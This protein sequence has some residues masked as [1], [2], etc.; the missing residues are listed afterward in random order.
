MMPEYRVMAWTTSEKECIKPS[1]L[2]SKGRTARAMS[3]EPSVMRKPAPIWAALPGQTKIK[4]EACAQ[5]RESH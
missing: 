4:T 1:S 3:S 5:T 2:S